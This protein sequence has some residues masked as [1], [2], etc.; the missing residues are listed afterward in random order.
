MNRIV[1]FFII[2]I[3]TVSSAQV[4][5][6]NGIKFK[7]VQPA[8]FH[9]RVSNFY[10][11]EIT[12]KNDVDGEM[13][14]RTFLAG[15]SGSEPFRT[16]YNRYYTK[17][18]DMSFTDKEQDKSEKDSISL[19]KFN[20]GLPKVFTPSP[21]SVDKK[22]TDGKVIGHTWHYRVSFEV[23]FSYHF[24]DENGKTVITK[25][26]EDG[27]ITYHYPQE[28]PSQPAK[29][30]HS[31]K[32][33]MDG[34]KIDEKNA[35]VTFRKKYVNSK[36]IEIKFAIYNALND[37]DFTK[38]FFIS[39]LK[40]KGK[41]KDVWADITSLGERIG[42]GVG[43]INENFKTGNK[44]NWHT[45]ELQKEFRAIG[46]EYLRLMATDSKKDRFSDTGR[47]A[48]TKNAMWCYLF[49]GDFAKVIKEAESRIEADER[50]STT[51]ADY[52][53]N[54]FL[55]LNIK[56]NNILEFAKTYEKVYLANKVKLGWL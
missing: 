30:F 1:F 41:Q 31:K 47:E 53:L 32:S 15:R 17:L 35:I 10:N 38:K 55:G 42:A 44:I 29:E 33:L 11:I 25:N 49:A 27:I 4:L 45:E 22:N 19:L 26:F 13:V 48:F 7:Y 5:K 21:Y 3:S 56:W 9:E 16:K 36:Y 2:L 40:L 24:L 6:K 54:S 43:I 52:E 39:Y 34:W 18:K 8:T 37:N 14:E 46:D 50:E 12:E 28:Y 20:I 51:N 23:T